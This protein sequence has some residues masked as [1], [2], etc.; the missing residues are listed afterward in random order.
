MSIS[1]FKGQTQFVDAATA[2]FEVTKMVTGL[3]LSALATA[4]ADEARRAETVFSLA[5]RDFGPGQ[6][7]WRNRHGQLSKLVQRTIDAATMAAL[8]D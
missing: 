6:L 7:V 1:S 4:S 8:Q 3:D 5:L 2:A